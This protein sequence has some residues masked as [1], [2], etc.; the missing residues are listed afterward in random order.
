RR[1]ADGGLIHRTR[2]WAPALPRSRVRCGV[3]PCYNRYMSVVAPLHSA[4]L[5]RGYRWR[6]VRRIIY[7][8]GVGVA[9][10]VVIYYWP[11]ISRLGVRMYWERKSLGYT[12]PAGSIVYSSD[13]QDISRLSGGGYITSWKLWPAWTFVLKPNHT[14]Q[15]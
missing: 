3:I 8:V 12:A 9:L 2:S 5:P 11:M 10:L 14:F 15:K 4:P 6:S 13:P 7:G 1:S